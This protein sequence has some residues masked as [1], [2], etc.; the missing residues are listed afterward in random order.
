MVAKPTTLRF[1]PSPLTIPTNCSSPLSRWRVGYERGKTMTI[2]LMI[3]LIIGTAAMGI[4]ILLVSKRYDIAWWKSIA[5]TILLTISGTCGTV[6]MFF[7]ENHSFGGR[8]FFGAVFFVPVLFILISRVLRISYTDA[9]D[10]CAVGECIM[11]A[12]M[13]I[14]CMMGGCCV[15]RILYTTASG[16]ALLFPSRSAELLSALVIFTVLLRWALNQKHRGA[17]YPLYLIIYG[18]VRF[19][20]NCFRQEW[21]TTSMWIPFGNIWAMVAIIVGLIWLKKQRKSAFVI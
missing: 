11:L 19:I 12:L 6:L 5:L 17:L 4:P 18:S 13:K 8:S 14:H 16:T 3:F 21:V 1:L 7:V 20:L 15:G 9:V 10:L 2:E